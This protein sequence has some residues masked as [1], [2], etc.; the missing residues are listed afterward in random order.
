MTKTL[1]DREGHEICRKVVRGDEHIS[2]FS[3][4][5]CIS[6]VIVHLLVYIELFIHKIK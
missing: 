1:K 5:P 4:E 6:C 3:N 2:I